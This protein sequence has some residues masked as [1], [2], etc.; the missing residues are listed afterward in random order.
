MSSYKQSSGG[1]ASTAAALMVVG[2]AAGA[3]ITWAMTS[4]GK[5]KL[6]ALGVSDI[7]PKDVLKRASEA[8]TKTR[9]RIVEAVDSRSIG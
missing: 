9:D 2:L 8:L 6:A 4:A 7:L 3:F 5:E 1:S